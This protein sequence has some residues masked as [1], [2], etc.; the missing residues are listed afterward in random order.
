[1]IPKV[2]S[3]TFARVSTELTRIPDQP[4]ALGSQLA[5]AA[6]NLARYL[7]L[8]LEGADNTVLAYS[9]LR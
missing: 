1:M 9:G 5:T 7:K 4:Q 3:A 2:I 8:G 6:D